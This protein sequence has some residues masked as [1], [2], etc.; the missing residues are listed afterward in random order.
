MASCLPS[1]LLAELLRDLAPAL[2]M[3]SCLPSSLLAELLRGLAPQ[4]HVADCN[5]GGTGR[6]WHLALAE[7]AEFLAEATDA[8][9]VALDAYA[10]TAACHALART[11]P[12]VRLHCHR[13]TGDAA[14]LH[15]T[16]DGPPP[17]LEAGQALA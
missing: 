8:N 16:K 2:P 10:L 11:W 5:Q 1:S 14:L 13:S 15:C 12:L 4:L 17:S 6:R 9:I 7:A 3:A